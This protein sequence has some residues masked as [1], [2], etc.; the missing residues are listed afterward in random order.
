[1]RTWYDP[2]SQRAT[3]MNDEPFPGSPDDMMQ[4]LAALRAENERLKEGAD[5]C[6]LLAQRLTI[7]NDRLKEALDQAEAVLS[8]VEPRSDKAEYLRVLGVVRAA[9][10]MGEIR[11][12]F[13]TQT[14]T[15]LEKHGISEE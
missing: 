2:P 9:L 3:E 8:I 5:A 7:E 4:R 11:A 10:K 12:A 14:G 1:Y 13:P 15:P 6:V